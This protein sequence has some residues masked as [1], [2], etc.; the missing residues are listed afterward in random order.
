MDFFWNNTFQLKH[1]EKRTSLM[2][3]PTEKAALVLQESISVTESQ[4]TIK[5]VQLKS[6]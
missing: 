2:T 5:K 1:N 6:S 3:G 4:L